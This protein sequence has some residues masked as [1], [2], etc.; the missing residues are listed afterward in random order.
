MR[1]ERRYGYDRLGAE[2]FWLFRPRIAPRLLLLLLAATAGAILA[3]GLGSMAVPRAGILGWMRGDALDGTVAL[4]LR[5]LRLPRIL[6]ALL[7][8]AMLGVAGAAMQAVTRNGLADPGLI[9]VKEGAIIALLLLGVAAPETPS[10][11]R[12]LT[13]FLGGSVVA[14]FVILLAGRL[15]GLRFVLIGIGVSWL[16]AAGLSLYMT[17]ARVTDAQTALIWLSGSLHATS[18]PD[19]RAALPWAVCGLALLLATAGAS[20]VAVLGDRVAAG[21][22]LGTR[23]LG[24]VWLA[25]PV[26]LTAASAAA[27][28]GLGFVGLIAPHLAR[29]LAGGRQVSVLLASGLV[30]G[31]LVLAADTIGRTIFAPVQ[32]PAGIVIAVLGAPFLGLLLLKGGRTL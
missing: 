3:L 12:P 17:T 6:M 32:I 30:G 8:G 31:L 21:L 24:L 13:G 16:L 14:G 27:I 19:I 22:G 9:G 15:S 26:M 20:D 25:A 2:R 28:G 5:E 7:G 10:A 1:A 11:W 4:V 18:W 29:A 23:A